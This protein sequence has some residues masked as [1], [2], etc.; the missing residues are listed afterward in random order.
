MYQINSKEE[1]NAVYDELSKRGWAN[2]GTSPNNHFWLGLRQYNS[3]ELNPNNKVDEGWYWLDGRLLTSE[4]A[5][6]APAEPNDYPSSEENGE[7]D[8]G[9]FD[10]GG[11]AKKWNDM[12]NIQD[13]G[14]SWP[15]FEFN[16]TTSVK[17]GEY[18][19]NEKTEFNLF[20]EATSSLTVTP[21]KTTIYFLEVTIDGVAC[22]TEYTIN[23]NPDPIS[24]GVGDFI[25]C[26]DSLDGDDT[27]GIIQSINFETLSS[28][29]LG[30]T[31]STLSLIHI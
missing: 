16:G 28:T 9:Q 2:E 10:F 8:Y 26:D 14:N 12:T 23:V 3:V 1:G 15:I 27:N 18:T 22:R 5:N 13:S 20:D 17:W 4:L 7:E 25:F 29:I 24:N 21:D 11:V 31:Q 6:W 19:N 30:N